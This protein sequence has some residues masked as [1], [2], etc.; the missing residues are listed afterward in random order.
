M[1]VDQLSWDRRRHPHSGR[2]EYSRAARGVAAAATQILDRGTADEQR[3]HVRTL[4]L[5]STG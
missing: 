4:Q 1:L 2:A 3:T 5:P